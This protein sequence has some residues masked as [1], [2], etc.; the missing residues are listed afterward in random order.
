M[1]SVKGLGGVAEILLMLAEGRLEEMRDAHGLVGQVETGFR[2]ILPRN[3]KS[4]LVFS[5]V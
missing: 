2:R 3:Q 4:E 5:S 1:S